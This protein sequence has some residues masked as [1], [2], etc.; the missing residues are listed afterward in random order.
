VI[1]GVF[2]IV[3]MLLILVAL[4]VVHEF[5]HFATARLFK[6][7][8][9]EFGI[10]FPPRA[11][12]LGR[13]SETVYTLNWLPLGGFV[14]L[15]GE[16]GDSD[17]PRSFVRQPLS[18]RVVILLA[19]VVMNLLL[20]FLLLWGI[21]AFADPTVG[22]RVSCVQPGS[23]AEQA[24]LVSGPVTRTT[25][26]GV[27]VCGDSGYTI[28]AVD[29]ERFSWFDAPA[30]I[31]DGILRDL[32]TKLGQTVSLTVQAPDGSVT[33]RSATLRSGD[34]AT[35][36]AL[37]IG[38]GG[39]PVGEGIIARDPISA[40]GVGVDRTV[41]AGTL[42]LDGLRQLVTNLANPPVSGP[43]GIVQ[44]VGVVRAEFPPVFLVYL[45]ALLSA[46]LAVVNALPFPP[47]DGGRLA[48]S[49]IQAISGNRVSLAAERAVYL[50]GFVLLMA[51]LVWISFFDIQRLGG[52]T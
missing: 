32:R 36:G 46:N 9:H 5:G 51:L 42:I 30:G 18:K 1:N 15:E 4:V 29:G 41:K 52:G 8:V 37:G 38:V 48:V 43:I 7:R 49:V 47:M 23:P 2:D 28:L 45:V 20:A 14:R 24:G 31:P 22:V 16:E 11:K 39:L 3:L 44:T 34:A 26:E 17:D 33:E 6:V 21:A 40:I 35:Q 13:D 27:A 50:T 19:G 12:V 10:G 25:P